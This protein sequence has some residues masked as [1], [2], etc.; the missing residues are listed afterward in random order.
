MGLGWGSEADGGH[1]TADLTLRPLV[2]EIQMSASWVQAPRLRMFPNFLNFLA[3]GSKR[4][5]PSQ[6][7]RI[8]YQTSCF[9][10]RQVVQVLSNEYLGFKLEKRSSGM[11]RRREHGPGQLI[12]LCPPRCY[13]AP[14]QQIASSGQSV[15]TSLL[16]ETHESGCTPPLP[17]PWQA[18]TLSNPDTKF[19]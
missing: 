9:C 2:L 11:T 15:R 10:R 5:H 17:V 6:L 19:P 3:T 8:R 16:L 7:S 1:Q 12:V 14:K 18:A 13:S 4:Q